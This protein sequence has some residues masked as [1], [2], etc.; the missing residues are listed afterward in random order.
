MAMIFPGMDPYLEDPRIWTEVHTSLI[1]YIRDYLQPLLRPRYRAAIESRVFVEGPDR[2]IIPDV[3]LRRS[4]PD[5]GK[6]GVAL[7][8]GD[9]PLLVRVPEVEIHQRYLEIHDRRSGQRVVTTIEVVSPTNKYGGPG[10]TLYLN[11]QQEVRNSETHLVEIDLLRKGHHSTA[12]P[13]EPA[14]AACGPFDY[15]VSVHPFDDVET[16]YVYPMNLKEPLATIEVPLLPG[17][18]AISLDLQ[19]VFDRCYDAGPYAREVDY[20]ESQIIPPLDANQAAWA[21]AML[22]NKRD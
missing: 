5:S 11:K 2:E 3:W 21:T 16:Y 14:L 10:R 7:A 19:A 4:R 20:G 13:L 17:D 12:V 1:V 8:N 22:Q 15:H 18:A 9:A 6:T